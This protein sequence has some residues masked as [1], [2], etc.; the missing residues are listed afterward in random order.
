MIGSVSNK[1]G[2]LATISRLFGMTQVYGWQSVVFGTILFIALAPAGAYAAACALSIPT[3]GCT[4]NSPGT[5]T[6]TGTSPMNSTGTCIDITA[7]NVKLIGGKAIK[8]PGS[9]SPTFGVHIEPTANKVFLDDIGA[10]DFGQGVRVDGPNASLI[11]VQTEGNNKGIVVNGANAYLVETISE[12][13]NLVGIQV[14]STA[15]DFVMVIGGALGATGAGLELNGVN[16]AFIEEAEAE[17]NGTFGIWLKSASDNFIAGFVSESNGIA[18]VYLGCKA[19]GPNGTACPAAVPSS[20]GNSLMGSVHG[21]STNSIVSNTGTP[22]N[23]RFGV[24]VGLGNLHNH[25]LLITGTGNVDDDALD[26]N[27]NCA[28]NRWAFDSFTTSSPAKGTTFF[29]LN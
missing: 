10:E 24:A 11:E 4:I 1:I 26:E 18:G 3:C 22:F 5:Y 17:G 9:T 6:L 23:Q 2:G 12:L 15:T 14:N 13:D 21:T 7:S 16:G 28:S 8:G 19:A 25:F 29:C 27:P 20:N